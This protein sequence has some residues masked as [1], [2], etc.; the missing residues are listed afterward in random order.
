MSN[1]QSMWEYNELEIE[2]PRLKALISSIPELR[3]GQ[4]GEVSLRV[5]TWGELEIESHT[6]NR[7]V[8]MCLS[9]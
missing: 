1:S 4:W 7:R 5:K 2:K 9:P 8:R 3:V 6:K